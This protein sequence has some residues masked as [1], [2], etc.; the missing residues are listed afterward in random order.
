MPAPDDC[1][2][3]AAAIPLRAD[4]ETGRLQVLLIRR[5]G[6]ADWGIPKGHVDPG[7]T[8]AEAAAIEAHEE[9]GV[10]GHLSPD[11]VGS[12]TYDKDGDTC[13]VQVFTMRVTVEHPRWEEQSIRQ[14]HWFDADEAARTVGREAVARLIRRLGDPDAR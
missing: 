14:R 13:L 11:P 9:A 1:I 2:P 8:P 5:Q 10:E 12:F 4:P 3:Q 6:R 7:H